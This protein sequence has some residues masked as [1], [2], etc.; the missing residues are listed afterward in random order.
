MR[1]VLKIQ[2]DKLHGQ[3]FVYKDLDKSKLEKFWSQ[4]TKIPLSQ[5][6]KTILLKQKNSKY[7]PNKNGTFKIRY[8]NKELRLV[9]ERMVNRLF[10]I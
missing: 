7:S 5:F 1:E 2:E 8:H 6:N 4:Q 10:E 9:L 3:L